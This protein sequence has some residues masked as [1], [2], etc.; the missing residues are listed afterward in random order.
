MCIIDHYTAT[1]DKKLRIVAELKKNVDR[2]LSRC[3]KQLELFQAEM[4]AEQP[5]IT[6]QL[7]ANALEIDDRTQEQTHNNKQ[8]DFEYD[9]KQFRHTH[10]S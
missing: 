7:E 3:D 9:E 5:G 4:E 10:V 6:R 8:N 1:S 2:Y